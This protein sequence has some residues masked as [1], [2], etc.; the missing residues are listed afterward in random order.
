MGWL[1]D[2]SK[3]EFESPEQAEKVLGDV[4]GL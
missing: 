4:M 1:F 3:S 2:G